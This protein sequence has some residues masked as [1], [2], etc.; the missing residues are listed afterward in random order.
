MTAALTDAL[1][2]LATLSKARQDDAA[3]ILLTM[4]EHDT[5]PYILSV[6]Q[7]E[8]IDAAIGEADAHRFATES[9]VHHVLREPW[10]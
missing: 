10:A 5:R 4:I 3:H 9:D 6:E 2:K 7:L 8:A 1:R